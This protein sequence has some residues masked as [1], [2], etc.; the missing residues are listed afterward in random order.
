MRQVIRVLVNGQAGS[1][2]SE[3]DRSQLVEQLASALP[4]A[5][6]RWTDAN[7]TMDQLIHQAMQESPTMLVAGGGDWK[8][9]SGVGAIGHEGHRTGQRTCTGPGVG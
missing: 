7:V 5:I 6:I 8:S 4:N 3:S 2:N 9:E 1:V